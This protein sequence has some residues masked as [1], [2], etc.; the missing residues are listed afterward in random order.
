MRDV[1]PTSTTQ[2]PTYGNWIPASDFRLQEGG[3]RLPTPD[4]QLPEAEFQLPTS[5]SWELGSRSSFWAI[6]SPILFSVLP[7]VASLLLPLFFVLY[8]S[9]L[10]PAPPFSSL[11]PLPSLLFPLFSYSFGR[12]DAR[13]R[14]V[15]LFGLR[16]SWRVRCYGCGWYPCTLGC[17]R[18][19][20]G[21]RLPGLLAGPVVGG[22]V[23]GWSSV[24]WSGVASA[25]GLCL[26]GCFV[27]GCAAGWV[28]PAGGGWVAVARL[29]AGGVFRFSRLVL[30]SLS[31]CRLFW[32]QLSVVGSL[33]CTV[34][35]RW[36]LSLFLVSF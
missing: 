8:S 7:S 5:G 3:F 17:L 20:V 21:C 18:W 26:A 23:F 31:V 28:G 12:G 33:R 19:Q 13:P 22:L 2:L 25:V 16:C 27:A 9:F 14:A 24:V 34:A 10:S 15:W 30:R 32:F 1:I 29:R 35:C 36:G 11:P 6:F 4:F